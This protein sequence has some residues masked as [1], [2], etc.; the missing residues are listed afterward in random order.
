MIVTLA[1]AND[2]LRRQ[3]LDRLIA[4]FTQQYDDMAVER[5]DG[6]DSSPDRLREAVSSLPFLTPRKLVMLRDAGKQ[7]P[8]AE[9]VGDLLKD[10]PETSDIIFYE[11]ALDKRSSYYKT[12]KKLTDFREFT[13]PDAGGLARWAVSYAKEQGG[14]LNMPDATNLIQRLG[15]NQRLLHSELLSYNPVITPEAIELLIERTPQSTVFELIDAAF[16]GNHQRAFD[17]YT[18]QRAQR[19]EPQA[20][21]AMLAWQ[22]HIL[23]VVKAAGQR[24]AD[25]IAVQTKLSPFVIHKSQGLVRQLSLEHIKRLINDLLQLD[26][27]LKR[28]PIDADEA[29][30]NY[31]LAIR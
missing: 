22:L 18:E 17:L 26:A 7:K 27:Q 28:S 14:S 30:Q 3:A 13:M 24:T 29:L 5:L 19:V 20:I 15:V 16:A 11:P 25:D 6:E 21:I 1:G 10:I 4:D 23:A 2:Y 12:L 9:T 31:L 8:F